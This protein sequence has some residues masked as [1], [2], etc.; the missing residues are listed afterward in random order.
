MLKYKNLRKI[1]LFLQI[2]K[3]WYNNENNFIYLAIKN[4]VVIDI[5]IDN[6]KIKENYTIKEIEDF[7]YS[8]LEKLENKEEKIDYKLYEID[9]E[10]LNDE[11]RKAY[12]TYKNM[13]FEEL[14]KKFISI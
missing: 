14:E 11:E 9:Y 8:Q 12:G 2:K 1:K 3:I 10:D 13:S 4:M 5:K 6:P 7:L